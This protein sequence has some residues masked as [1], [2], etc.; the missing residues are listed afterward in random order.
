MQKTYKTKEKRNPDAESIRINGLYKPALAPSKFI[1]PKSE[2]PQFS[3]SSFPCS[4]VT[5]STVER[6]GEREREREKD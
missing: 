1:S 3:S 6:E 2:F 4:L 5:E